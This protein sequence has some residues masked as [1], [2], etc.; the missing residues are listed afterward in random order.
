MTSLDGPGFSITLLKATSEILEY[1]D[2]PTTAVGWSAPSFA[3]SSWENQPSR[4]VSTLDEIKG[5]EVAIESGMNRECIEYSFRLSTYK[6]F[7]R[8]PCLQSQ[9]LA[10]LQKCHSR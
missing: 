9:S 8:Y 5:K 7:S 1:I 4:Q 6:F 10:S 3:P 2:A